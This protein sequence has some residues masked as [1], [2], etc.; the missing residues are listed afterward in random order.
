M[1]RV[2]RKAKGKGKFIVA[3]GALLAAGLGLS[4]ASN[5][6]PQKTNLQPNEVDSTGEPI[7]DELKKHTEILSH[8]SGGIDKY[9]ESS[10]S[11]EGGYGLGGAV[12]DLAVGLATDP[13][14][15]TSL[16]TKALGSK[17]GQK[18][19]TNIAPKLASKLALG[20]TT[21]ALAGPLG[22]GGLAVDGINML[23]QGM[24]WWEEDGAVAKT[25]DIGGST[26][27]GAGIGATI[28]SVVPVPVVGTAVGAAVGAGVGALVGV[29]D[30]IKEGLQSWDRKTS[31][32]L[33]SDSIGDKLLGGISW[34]GH[35]L[36]EN[37]LPGI[38]A[39]LFG[40]T[41]RQ[42]LLM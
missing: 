5:D 11:E 22:W 36:A 9:S 15:A 38:I 32:L 24:G 34:V 39:N 29:S 26:L 20:A 40:E 7:L 13:Y 17:L 14:I 16:G 23:G 42:I 6:T 18:T 12:G 35:T 10:R 19:I 3:A 25:L 37:S 31:E 27:T 4:A 8:M 21:K 28:G 30:D 41:E 2:M 1:K 33:D